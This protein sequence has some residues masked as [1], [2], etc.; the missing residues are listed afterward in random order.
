MQAA[1][2][3]LKAMGIQLDW[4]NLK[5][6]YN[7]FH[8]KDPAV[9]EKALQT[10]ISRCTAKKIDTVDKYFGWILGNL[11]KITTPTTLLTP[12]AVAC[13]YPMLNPVSSEIKFAASTTPIMIG[14]VNLGSP[15]RGLTA[16]YS[17]EHILHYISLS[18]TLC[19]KNNLKLLD[20]LPLWAKWDIE[21]LLSSGANIFDPP[22]LANNTT[23]E[24]F[25]NNIKTILHYNSDDSNSYNPKHDGEEV[26]PLLRCKIECDD[27]QKF[28][29]HLAPVHWRRGCRLSRKVGWQKCLRVTTSGLQ[30][31]SLSQFLVEGNRVLSILNHKFK[32]LCAKPE[33]K[34]L[35][36]VFLEEDKFTCAH[37]QE[38]HLPSSLNQDISLCKFAA[39]FQ[40]MLSTTTPLS[41]TI[42]PEVHVSSFI[43]DI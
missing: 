17:S 33:H 31:K 32:F 43:S 39:R 27:A 22:L 9:A 24:E 5:K 13:S 3:K 25:V 28:T 36:L 14:S 41:V 23:A 15:P 30:T 26:E 37:I 7:E 18:D 1:F 40:L 4:R 34:Q 12:S 42:S 35:E 8:L 10:L 6:L 29:V 11:D 16:C 21:V 20:A 19:P 38:W 2:E